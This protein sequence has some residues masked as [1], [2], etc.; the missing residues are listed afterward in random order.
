MSD[1]CVVLLAGHGPSTN[2]VYHA[3]HRHLAETARI[4]VI[5]EKSVSRWVLL[6]RRVKRLGLLP[7]LGQAAFVGGAVPLLRAAA[8]RRVEAIKA[9]YGLD[10][11]PIP[12]STHAVD[13]VN[14]AETRRLL[15]ELA[16]AVV[17]VNGTRILN[18]ETLGSS[19]APF[20]NMHAGITPAYRGVH[21][22]YWALVE[23]RP[24]LVGTTVHRVDEGIDTGTII[25]Q[26]AFSVTPEDTFWTYPYLHTAAG[27][28]L[29][30]RAVD[31][32]LE[33]EIP[34]RS[35]DPALRSTLR[36]HPTIWGYASARLRLGVK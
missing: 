1:R 23:G 16:P 13:S 8:Q 9:E 7:V 6:K 18:R 12:A 3:L 20:V 27:I 21:G 30:L 26:A 33:G 34:A 32:A 24:D 29:L 17:V 4:E 36:Y 28:P 22:G 19:T 5:Q 15:R 14:S 35:P 10:D 2:I 31:A 25:D 11:A